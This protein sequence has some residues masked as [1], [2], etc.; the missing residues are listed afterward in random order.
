MRPVQVVEDETVVEYPVNQALLTENYTRRAEAFLEEAH[1]R[2]KPFFLYFAHAMPHKPLAA[3][4]DFW[5]PDTPDDLYLDVIRELDAS[6]GRVLDRVRDLGIEEETLVIFLSDNGPSWGG[7]TGGLRGRKSYTWEG[8]LRVPFIAWQPGVIPAGMESAEPAAVIDL[9]PTLIQQAGLMARG[10]KPL[11]GKN[12][13]ALMTR[14]GAP[15]PHEALFSMKGNRIMTVASGPWRLHLERPGTW[16][17]E[18]RDRDPQDDPRRPDGIT[19]FAQWEQASTYPG[20]ANPNASR[21]RPMMLFN[22][23]E[24]PAE[25]VDVSSR[26]PE[27][28]EKL[29]ALYEAEKE[30]AVPMEPVRGKGLM[31][32]HGGDFEYRPFANPMVPR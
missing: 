3:S 9:F 18:G 1:R 28:V 12:I 21:P 20:V 22:V 6:V 10:G 19:I 7:D 13:W 32:I 8:G 29:K 4:P 23:V 5:T 16:E 27:V 15:S 24:D 17:S 25:Q 14:K 30:T 31:Y 26:Y 2:N 11:D